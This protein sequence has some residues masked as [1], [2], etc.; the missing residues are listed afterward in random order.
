MKR[1]VVKYKVGLMLAEA[2]I[3][4]FVTAAEIL[5]ISPQYLSMILSCERRPAKIQ[6]ALARL[7]H[8]KP[9]DL[10]GPFTHP[11]LRCLS[12]LKI[13]KRTQRHES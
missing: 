6:R 2:G 11:D 4:S 7:C 8:H 1:E 9:Q 5:G 13:A 12:R 3:S 10:F